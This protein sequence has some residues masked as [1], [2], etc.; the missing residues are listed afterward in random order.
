MNN[1]PPDL[2]IQKSDSKEGPVQFST[3]HVP[4]D[5]AHRAVDTATTP[6]SPNTR[7]ARLVTGEVDELQQQQKAQTRELSDKNNLSSS[8]DSKVNKSA[9]KP[10]I[11]Q[12]HSLYEQRS[13][14]RYY[15]KRGVTHPG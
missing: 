10:I 2:D 5:P 14:Y 4:V 15:Q 12:E 9:N 6:E 8:K 11:I 7:Q 1:V 3:D 13:K